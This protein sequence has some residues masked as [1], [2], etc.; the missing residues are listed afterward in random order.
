MKKINYLLLLVASIMFIACSEENDEQPSQPNQTPVKVE[1]LPDG[2]KIGDETVQLNSAQLDNLLSVDEENSTL[3]FSATLNKEYIPQKGDILLQYYPTESLPYG[4]LGRVINVKMNGDK[5]IVETEAPSLNEA[6]DNFCVTQEI[7]IKTNDS[8]ALIETGNDGY[9][10][11]NPEGSLNFP[12]GSIGGN[13]GIGGKITINNTLDAENNIDQTEFVL[14]T[15]LQAGLN[16][17]VKAKS[18]KQVTHSLPIL[19]EGV[20]IPTP[21]KSFGLKLTMIPSFVVKF[22][23]EVGCNFET[24]IEATKSF[25]ISNTGYNE[26]DNNKPDGSFDVD[27]DAGFYL[28]GSVF[29]GLSAEFELSFFGRDEIKA[30]ITP[31]LG[32]NISAALTSDFAKS[33]YTAFKDTQITTAVGFGVG[34]TVS[35][36]IFNLNAELEVPLVSVTFGGKSHYLFPDFKNG[37]YSVDGDNNANGTIEVERDLFWKNDI[38]IGCYNTDGNLVEVNG[39]LPYKR[40]E[41]FSNPLTAS[42][43]HN[44]DNTYWSVIKWGGGYLKCVELDSDESQYILSKIHLKNEDIE[45]VIT[46]EYDDLGRIKKVIEDSTEEHD[47]VYVFDYNTNQINI[48]YDNGTVTI[49]HTLNEFGLI[50]TIT[51]YIIESNIITGY[52]TY[53]EDKRVATGTHIHTLTNTENETSVGTY[54]W[55]G[56]NLASI[57]YNDGYTQTYKYNSV[58]N[59]KTN[60]DL[61]HIVIGLFDESGFPIHLEVADWVTFYLT[62]QGFTGPRSKNFILSELYYDETYTYTWEF[63]SSGVPT[64][65]IASGC[66]EYLTY[67]FEYQ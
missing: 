45:C 59:N 14:D 60:V 9:T 13:I 63:S 30:D 23:G 18:E 55:D 1:K 53:T 52:F 40:N 67:T 26:T 20:E 35:V 4:F 61:N 32:G 8:R 25:K 50:K 65:C 39:L 31:E 10:M 29:V 27:V 66:G 19:K 44:Q 33:G 58:L 56:D 48:T 51:N 21:A 37:A 43:T 49:P 7:E 41:Q 3:T 24:E 6:F 42:F 11:I 46:F 62:S 57:T 38:A 64:S 36:K 28:N 54:K 16:F 15:K 34:A 12:N 2:V 22:E 17:S 5:I 47:D